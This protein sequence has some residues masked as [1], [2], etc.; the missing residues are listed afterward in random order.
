M[1]VLSKNNGNVIRKST[2]FLVSNIKHR[3]EKSNLENDEKAL[4]EGILLGDKSGISEN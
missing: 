3:I 4:L 2:F 1:K